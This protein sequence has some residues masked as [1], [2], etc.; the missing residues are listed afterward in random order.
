M[1]GC[2][3][4]LSIN[5]DLIPRSILQAKP[6]RFCVRL[7]DIGDKISYM[8]RDKDGIELCIEDLEG[9]VL[10]K[11]KIKESR[12]AFS[13]NW[14]YTNKHI[15][16]AQDADGDEN[17]HVFC[18]DIE[19]GASKDLT[20]FKGARSKVCNLS[21]KYPCEAILASN[22]NDPKWFEAYRVNIVTGKTDLVFK[23]SSYAGF[24]FDHDLNLRIV[25]EN[26]P[27]GSDIYLIKNGKPEFF[28]KV[29]F[30]DTKS[31]G[32]N[33]L[34]SNNR[35][36]YGFESIGRDKSALVAYD[37]QSKT[38]RVIFKS[39]LADV[40]RFGVDPSTY[41]PQ[42]AVV[43]YLSPEIFVIDKNVSKDIAYLQSH[44]KG[45]FLDIV[46]ENLANDTWIVGYYSSDKCKKYCLY[47]RNP[48]S[49]EPISLKF[50]FS[51]LAKLDKYKLQKKE[52]IVIK[53]R[54]GLDLVCYLTRSYDFQTAN[55]RK[56]VVYVHGGPWARDENCLDRDVQ[57][58]ANR[59]YSV[60]QI[61]YRGS[62]GFGKKFINAANG[63]L[64]KIRDDVID[65][66]NWAIKNQIAD[67]SSIAIMGASFGGYSALAGLAFTPDTFCCGV[68]IVGP[69]NWITTLESIPKYWIPFAEAWYKLAGN[70]KTKEGIELLKRNSPITRVNDIKK[71]LMVFHGKNDPR[72]NKREADQI[73]NAVKSKGSLVGYVL[74][75]DEGHGFLRDPNNKSYSAFTEIFLAKIMGGRYEPIHKGELEG[76]SHQ[77]LEGK[78]LIEV[79]P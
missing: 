70:P 43:D 5:N 3:N 44:A 74:Y 76:S 71:S 53:S 30:E 77:I 66:V 11:F 34:D 67:K 25:S 69:A 23:N 31:T 48:V 1:S 54:D 28:K 27:D 41:A 79:C 49:G 18:L 9:N 51:A 37:L 46:S 40:S 52:P 57:L 26:M 14:A 13:Y 59:G 45:R 2:S 63:N 22:K 42:Y 55:P 56:L 50:L 7:N 4:H 20:P 16:I 75:P 8:S 15:L 61:N 38:S 24:M 17:D 47:K 39:D 12:G 36:I 68:D 33:Y 6:D 19:T 32:F 29:P 73:V 58:L 65:G 21:K 10:R 62:T 78:S 64:D 35:I 60:L 72:V